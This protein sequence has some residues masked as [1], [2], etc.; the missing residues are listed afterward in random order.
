MLGDVLMG[1]LDYWRFPNTRNSWGGP[2]NGQAARR[3]LF[4]ALI[5]EFDPRAI[6]ETGTYRGTTTE[7]MAAT[8]LPIFTIENDRRL[9]G[10][11][12]M[13]LCWR[14]NVRV[15][16]GDSRKI[17]RKLLAGPLRGRRDETLFYYL[18]AH[19]EKDLPLAEELDIVFRQSPGAIVMIDD[20]QVPFDS[21]YRYDRYKSG[22]AL[23]TDYIAPTISEHGLAAFYPSTLGSE[24]T[25]SKRGCVVLAIEARHGDRLSRIGMLRRA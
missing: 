16:H 9:Y 21:A 17:V 15:L 4:A 6:I 1:A 14:R 12:R 10:F 13:R 25:G 18:D 11:S 23:T 19:W 22:L 24:E 7:F 5:Q 20:F 2:F 8:G 3:R